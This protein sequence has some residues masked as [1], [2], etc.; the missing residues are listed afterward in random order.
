MIVRAPVSLLLHPEL[1]SSAKLIWLAGR[2]PYHPDATT[3]ARLRAVTG[4]SEPTIQRGRIRLNAAGWGP[5][6]EKHH[7]AAEPSVGLPTALVADC[8]LN[9]TAR[10]LYG[11]LQLTPEYRNQAGQFTYMQLS[12]I[13]PQGLKCIR[14]GVSELARTGWLRMEQANQCAPIL[15][16]LTDPIDAE[17]NLARSRLAKAPYRGEA[18]MREYLSLLIASDQYEDDAAPGFLINPLTQ[19]RMQ[20]DRYY[21]PD[22]AFEHNGPQHYGPTDRFSQEDAAK[23]QARDYMKIGI[24]H[25]RG[26]NLVIIHPE[27]LSLDGMR[28]KVGNRLPLRDLVGREP[29]IR[30]LESLSRRY[31][32]AARD[33]FGV[34]AH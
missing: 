25:L 7:P 13:L 8:R 4:L 6:A 29:L 16:T 33:G 28:R 21:P 3:P 19:E 22:V 12:R 23:Q 24:C 10:L 27:D 17:V 15:F 2:L 32:Q 31:R 11:V 34:R 1:P 20:L 18:L 26:I 30:W 9:A 5:T 14:R